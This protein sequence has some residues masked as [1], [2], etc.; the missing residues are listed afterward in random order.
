MVEYLFI[1]SATNGI[2]RSLCSVKFETYHGALVMVCRTFHRSLWIILL[3]DDLVHPH[4]WVPYVQI[5]LSTHLYTKVLFSRESLEFRPSS[6]DIWCTFKLRCWRFVL[7]CFCQ[8]N[9]WSR[10]RPRY[11]TSF[12]TGM[13]ILL[14]AT[15]GQFACFVVN[16]ICEDFVSFI[17]IFYLS[18]QSCRRSEWRWSRCDASTGS[19]SVARRAVSSAKVAIVVLLCCW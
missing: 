7:M 19:L 12:S 2:W 17:L 10:Y 3:F 11:F 8:V 1:S 5:G 13:C 16:V 14:I 6:H 4:S 9:F 15:G 18:D